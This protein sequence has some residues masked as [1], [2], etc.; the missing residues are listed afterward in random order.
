MTTPL[1]R[2]TSWANIDFRPRAPILGSPNPGRRSG[3]K[4]GQ[5]PGVGGGRFSAAESP[6]KGEFYGIIPQKLKGQIAT[7]P[8]LVTDKG[9]GS[10]P[11]TPPAGLPWPAQ[12]NF[13]RRPARYRRLPVLAGHWQANGQSVYALKSACPV[14]AGQLS[15]LD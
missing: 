12:N 2:G 1:S 11:G 10:H 14:R 13:L 7:D 4:K 6:Q 15:F 8:S 3:P 9:R 5:P